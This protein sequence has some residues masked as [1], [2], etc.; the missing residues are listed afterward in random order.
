MNAEV[1]TALENATDPFIDE[2]REGSL[3]LQMSYNGK[4]DKVILEL[5]TE[6]ESRVAIIDK[7]KVN[8][9]RIH[10]CLFVDD[11]ASLFKSAWQAPVESDDE[12]RAEKVR[13]NNEI[14]DQ[15]SHSDL[16]QQ[17]PFGKGKTNCECCGSLWDFYTG[18]GYFVTSDDFLMYLTRFLSD[19]D[20]D[21]VLTALGD[22]TELIVC[23]KCLKQVTGRDIEH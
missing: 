7:E 17:Y 19:N 12:I 10:P 16:K 14:Y 2:M 15:E 13:R 6:L 20:I 4:L 18:A 8:E 3:L 11:P 9:A 21:E 5:Q 1:I 23:E 22:Q